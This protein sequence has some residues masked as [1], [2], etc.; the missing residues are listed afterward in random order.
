MTRILLIAFLANL[1]C[2]CT[3]ERIEHDTTQALGVARLTDQLSVERSSR[4][5]V[6]DPGYLTIIA[7]YDPADPAQVALLNAA[8]AG[9]NRVYP[10][11]VLDPTPIGLNGPIAIDEQPIELLMHV[12]IPATASDINRF[13]IALV[14]GRTGNVIDRATLTLRPSW[15]GSANDPAAVEQ[16]FHDYAAQLRPSQ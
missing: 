11:T 1:T 9:V 5:R 15:R 12:D 10:R 3:I 14:E 16:L 8:F 13:P 6:D 2:G 7:E 4:W